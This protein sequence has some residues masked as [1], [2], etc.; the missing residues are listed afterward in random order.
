M[1]PKESIDLMNVEYE[2]VLHLYR[3]WRRSESALKDK[4]RELTELKE[5]VR[6]LQESHVK[7]RSQIQSLESVKELTISL[8][9]QLKTLKQENIQ[10]RN[11]NEELVHLN[12]EAERILQSKEEKELSQSKLIHNVQLDFATLKG[13]YEENDRAYKEL[14]KLANE[15]QSMRMGLDQRINDA[16]SSV[17]ELREENRSLRSQL[18]ATRRRVEQCDQELL[19]ASEQLSSISQEVLQVHVSKEQL[20]NAEAEMGVLRGNVQNSFCINILS[21]LILLMILPPL[22]LSPFILL[23]LVILLPMILLSIYDI[24]SLLPKLSQTI[25]NGTDKSFAYVYDDICLLQETLRDYC[26]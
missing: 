18:E 16:D 25:Y 24:F 3:G 2:D 20:A 13:R 12:Q 9:V 8:E 15:E 14:E 23:L 10:L 22:I 6:Q 4:D 11:D 7:F 26:D 21:P 1:Q 17:E 19:H 5:R